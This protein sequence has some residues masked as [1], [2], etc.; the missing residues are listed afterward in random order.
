M[1]WF[2]CDETVLLPA[3]AGTEINTDDNMLVENRVPREAFKPSMEEN[4]A[5]IQALA[6]QNPQT[7]NSNPQ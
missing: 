5:W 3:L 7:I 1:G 4:S 6:V 2:V